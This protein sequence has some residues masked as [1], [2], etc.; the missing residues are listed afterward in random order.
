MLQTLT[1]DY[2]YVLLDAALSISRVSLL[3]ILQNT[4][5]K[6]SM[7]KILL[8]ILLCYKKG[9][10]CTIHHIKID[11]CAMAH[12]FLSSLGQSNYLGSKKHISLLQSGY[13][14][15][16]DFYSSV[17]FKPLS[18]WHS[19]FSFSKMRWF[20]SNLQ[21]SG[22]IGKTTIAAQNC[23]VN[24]SLSVPLWH[25]LATVRQSFRIP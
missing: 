5:F 12:P 11:S 22:F 10:N 20:V 7:F 1:Y 24:N 18:S 21:A 2:S 3:V 15:N 4:F 13:N 16:I 25:I 9:S 23:I 6:N 14:E 17:V 8:N 19:L